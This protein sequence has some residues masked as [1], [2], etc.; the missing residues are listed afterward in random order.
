[1]RQ[2]RIPEFL[3]E[4][5]FLQ[6]HLDL[7]VF[8]MPFDVHEEGVLPLDPLGGTALDAGQVHAVGLEV[9]NM[10]LRAV[11]GGLSRRIF[12]I[13]Y[14]RLRPLPR[15]CWSGARSQS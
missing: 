6:G 12:S 10:L 14:S 8:G 9:L 3:I 4:S 13:G 5:F 7:R 1:M 11:T 2:N 15:G